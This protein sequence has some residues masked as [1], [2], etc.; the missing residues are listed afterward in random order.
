M[1]GDQPVAQGAYAQVGWYGLSPYARAEIDRIAR[2][3]Y[4]VEL[5]AGTDVETLRR[6][7]RIY[8]ASW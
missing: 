4:G 5:H 6:F 7:I 3:G 1:T 2:E 8:R